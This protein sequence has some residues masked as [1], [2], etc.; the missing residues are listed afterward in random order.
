MKQVSK[1]EWAD[2][3]VRYDYYN[4]V[5]DN[6]MLTKERGF[7]VILGKVDYT[8]PFNKKYYIRDDTDNK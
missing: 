5:V 2:Y 6:C 8:D 1:E 7:E 3:V 4:T